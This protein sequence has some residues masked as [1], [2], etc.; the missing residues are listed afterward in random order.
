M[1]PLLICTD[2]D[3]TLLPNGTQ[4]ESAGARHLFAKLVQR[5]NVTLA[6][7]T[8]RHLELI[9]EAIEEFDLPTP[10]FAISDVGSSI[11]QFGAMGWRRWRAWD[12]RIAPDWSNAG[13]DELAEILG[14]IGGLSLQEREKQGPHKLSFYTSLLNSSTDTIEK[15]KQKLACAGFS[16]NLIWSVD[17]H[18]HRGL[19]DILP[20]RANKLLAIEFLMQAHGFQRDQVV[21]CGDSGNDLDVLRSE[22]PTVLVANAGASLKAQ[23]N[24][25]QLRNFYVAHGGFLGMNGNYCAGI[26]EGVAHYRPDVAKWLHQLYKEPN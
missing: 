12:A 21:F 18:T 7:V 2:L 5:R 14:D 4:P 6:Y 20:G 24:A 13:P 17:E 23:L 8:G 1:R 3:R 22:L 16:T 15:V 25:E 19:L 9:E 10:D 11:Y 26:L